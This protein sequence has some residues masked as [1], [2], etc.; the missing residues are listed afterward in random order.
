MI[1]SSVGDNDEF[2]GWLLLDSFDYSPDQVQN[3]LAQK[4]VSQNNTYKLSYEQLT[5]DN[6]LAKENLRRYI[7]YTEIKNSVQKKYK[8]SD[9]IN[10][11]EVNIIAK[12]SDAPESPLSKSRRF[13]MS[14]PDASL[15]ITPQ[16]LIYNNTSQ[17]IKQKFFIGGH[18]KN[19]LFLLDGSKVSWEAIAGLP[20]DW[21][22][23]V[24]M[25]DNIASYAVFGTGTGKE[26]IDGVI[27]IITRDIPRNTSTKDY[28][29]INTKISGYNEPRIFYSPKHNK[30]DYNPDLRTTLF[31][32]PNITLENGKDYSLKFYNADISSI[33]KICVEGITTTG[34]PITGSINYKVQ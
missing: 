16:L 31:W 2:R 11:G 20:V 34:I 26:P 29:S 12:Q 23:R 25:S 18:V 8:L 1:V 17:L 10:I 24:D 13:L 5:N 19:P 30:P 33:I 27:S 3:S 21:V 32:E 28:H 7:Q 14:T 22:E 6:E 4:M 9:T 15:V